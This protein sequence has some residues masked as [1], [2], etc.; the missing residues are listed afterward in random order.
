MKVD[1]IIFRANVTYNKEVEKNLIGE[2][3][4]PLRLKANLSSLSA[5]SNYNQV[6]VKPKFDKDSMEVLT[7]IDELTKLTP[8]KLELPYGFELD[9]INGE[10]I[11]D[12]NGK[13]LYI[14]EYGNDIIR[15]YYPDDASS[16][17][18]SISERDKN[19]GALISKVE[20]LKRKDGSTKTNITIFDEKINNKYTIFHLEEDGTVNSIT[21]FSGK[22]KDFR[23]LFKNP[24]NNT[25][26]RYIEAKEN[27]SG[28]FEFLDCRLNSN[29]EVTDI[30]KLS[31]SKEVNI[32]YSGN[33]KIIDVKQRNID[34]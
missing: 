12:N 16:K 34:Y 29:Q 25:P 20:P 30:K 21:E 15:D 3:P 24:Y 5:L 11:Y 23:T 17:I 7:K 32:H 4:N 19:S 1:P 14:R 26:V 8:N 27:D 2:S 13:L 18:K 9:T 22:G 28:E 31:A 10:R 33:Q 6:L